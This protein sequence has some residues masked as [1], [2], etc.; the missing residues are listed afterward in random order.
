MSGSEIPFETKKENRLAHDTKNF[1]ADVYT[2]VVD[3]LIGTLDPNDY[4]IT[5]GETLQKI[6]QLEKDAWRV[7]G[8][9]RKLVKLLTQAKGDAKYLEVT[10]EN[11]ILTLKR[12]NPR[13][14]S[15]HSQNLRDKNGKR[16]PK[17]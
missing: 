2:M 4:F 11:G 13:K 17:S 14:K 8:E 12:K 7:A 5:S 9:A 16:I 1:D 10:W 3:D 15:R 6:K